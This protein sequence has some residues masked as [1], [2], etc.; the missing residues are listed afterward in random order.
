MD[1]DMFLNTIFGRVKVCHLRRQPCTGSVGHYRRNTSPLSLFFFFCVHAYLYGQNFVSLCNL[2]EFVELPSSL[3]QA[4][5]WVVASC[6]FCTVL[7]GLSGIVG[8]CWELWE[9]GAADKF[10]RN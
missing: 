4:R 10:D 6:P 8:N 1:V 5:V 2:R 7:T 9:S 3:L